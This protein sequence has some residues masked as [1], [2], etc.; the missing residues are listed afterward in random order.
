MRCVGP[1]NSRTLALWEGM[2]V[3]GSKHLISRCVHHLHKATIEEAREMRRFSKAQ[4][5]RSQFRSA[6]R[7]HE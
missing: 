2:V 4:M 1:L 6:D 3:G 7:F 5:N